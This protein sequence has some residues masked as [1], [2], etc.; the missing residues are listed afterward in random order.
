MPQS[1]RNCWARLLKRERDNGV[2]HA[3]AERRSGAVAVAIEM[4]MDEA[5]QTIQS[6]YDDR[7]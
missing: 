5:V 3:V 6:P 2:R 4:Q 7:K 1:R